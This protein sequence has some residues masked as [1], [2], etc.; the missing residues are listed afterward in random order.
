[1]LH[2]QSLYTVTVFLKETSF[3]LDPINLAPSTLGSEKNRQ[4]TKEI[5]IKEVNMYLSQQECWHMSHWKHGQKSHCLLSSPSAWW[6][7]ILPWLTPCRSHKPSNSCCHSTHTRLCNV[8]LTYEC[9]KKWNPDEICSEYLPGSYFN[10][11]QA[12][13][14]WTE[15]TAH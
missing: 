12:I 2:Q 1:M 8:Q 10:D 5:L 7:K 3:A 11:L 4:M 14:G 15:S 13:S 9:I 6:V